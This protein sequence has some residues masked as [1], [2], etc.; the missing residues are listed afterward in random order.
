MTTTWEV[1]RK[2]F[3][4]FVT[5]D[6]K[7][8]TNRLWLNRVCTQANSIT[9]SELLPGK[10]VLRVSSRRE[11]LT[12]WSDACGRDTTFQLIFSK[13]S[14]LFFH[15][16]RQVVRQREFERAEQGETLN[17]SWR[18]SAL[19]RSRRYTWTSMSMLLTLSNSCNN[20]RG[21]WD[22]KPERL[23]QLVRNHL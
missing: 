4:S 6:W 16:F 9:D 22:C 19:P 13:A 20:C 10:T 1:S 14:F 23:L 21:Y 7:K 15:F 18:S 12:R 2:L 11:N 3:F 8:P 5:N 17:Q